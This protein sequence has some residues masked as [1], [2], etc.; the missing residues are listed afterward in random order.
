M[1]RKK[2]LASTFLLILL[3]IAA[4]L[5]GSRMLIVL[6]PAALFVWYSARPM[7]DSNRN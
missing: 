5:G 3:G 7:L 4:L 2:S 1:A 6:V